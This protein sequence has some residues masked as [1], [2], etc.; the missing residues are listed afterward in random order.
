MAT[1]LV[2][3]GHG[4]NKDGSFDPGA[5]GIIKKGEHKYY[6]ENFFPAVRKYLP[7]GHKMVLFQDYNVYSY[8]NLASLANKY[9]K[10]TIVVEMHYDAATALASGGHVI[11]HEDYEPDS[12]DLKLAALI[13]KHIGVRY[14]HRGHV[15][16]SGRSDLRNCNIARASGINYRLVE[17]GFGTNSKDAKVMVNNVDAIAKD[18]VIALVGKAKTPTTNTSS[19][20]TYKVVAGDTLT[21]IAKKYK[22]TVLNLKIWNGLTS[23]LIK[24]G[25]VLKVA[26][27]SGTYTVKKGDTLSKIGLVVGV[28]WQE[29]AKKNNIKSP[30]IIQIGQKL[31]Y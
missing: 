17:L 7:E 14:S 15:G 30:Y 23:D 20:K 3:A 4:K 2:I 18:F 29:I 26:A 16:I 25:Q 21:A 9:G 10:D 8:N 13:K 24:V 31:K 28:D 27:P 19:S 1:I 5:T 12:Y 11:I 22:T 6:T